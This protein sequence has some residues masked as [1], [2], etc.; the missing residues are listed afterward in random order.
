M[1]PRNR[2]RYPRLSDPPQPPRVVVDVEERV[3]TGALVKCSFLRQQYEI[4]IPNLRADF[5]RLK[6]SAEMSSPPTGSAARR[7]ARVAGAQQARR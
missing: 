3:K 7:S 2:R 1:D 5:D 4:R 6:P